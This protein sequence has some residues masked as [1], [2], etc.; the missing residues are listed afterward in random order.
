M[1]IYI[2]TDHAGFELK[3]KI[4]AYLGELGYLAVDK[5]ALAYDA[6]DDYPDFVRPVAEAVASD[7]GTFGIVL[8]KSGQGEAICANRVMGVR[9]AV[10][11]GGSLDIV[12]LEREHNNA[13]ILSLGSAF[14]DE[15][16]AKKAV[17]L[18]L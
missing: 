6:N 13:N 16:G 5:G 11:Y 14:L 2:G 15:E 9:C 18:F 8:G 17:K 1:K 10:F 7:V 3:N 4:K 12:R